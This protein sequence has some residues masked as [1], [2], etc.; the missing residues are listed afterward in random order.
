MKDSLRLLVLLAV[1]GLLAGCRPAE[2]MQ[3]PPDTEITR[4]EQAARGSE[5]VAG[6][7]RLASLDRHY[8]PAAA[9]M[10]GRCTIL[11]ADGT[12]TLTADG[13][14][15]MRLETTSECDGERRQH[16][17]ADVVVKEGL[18]S[19][20]GFRLRFGDKMIVGRPD[21]APETTTGPEALVEAIFHY[22]RFA[23]VGTYR[24]GRITATMRDLR[25]FEFA[26]S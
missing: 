1:I 5:A 26:R 16:G 23:A 10:D 21:L 7:Y 15:E 6:T 20:A 17:E 24:A 12:L 3:P 25:T 19:L 9:G 13:R 8:L 4:Y 22:G 11:L 18:Y 14:Y 2:P